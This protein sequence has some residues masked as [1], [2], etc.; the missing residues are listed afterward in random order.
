MTQKNNPL[1]ITFDEHGRKVFVDPDA[2]MEAIKR[3]LDS[4]FAGKAFGT[5]DGSHTVSS[6][7][8][9]TVSATL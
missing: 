9:K 8:A 2:A 5:G 3:E 4:R 1:A 7:S 6:R